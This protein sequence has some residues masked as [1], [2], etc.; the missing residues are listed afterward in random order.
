MKS[1]YEL[2]M[3]RLE[4]QSPSKKLSEEQKRTLAEI[5]SR[6]AAKIAE[7][8]LFIEGEIAKLEPHSPE[9]ESLQDQLLSET[10]RLEE[11]REEEKEK[12]RNQG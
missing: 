4:R 1:A 9:R 7:K 12:I 2:A 5:D 8:R 6:F 10:R 11:Q 3:S